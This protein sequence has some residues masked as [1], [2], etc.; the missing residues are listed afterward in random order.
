MVDV[1]LLEEYTLLTE[2]YS[3]RMFRLSCASPQLSRNMRGEY[4]SVSS[5]L[6]GDPVPHR[7]G[8]AAPNFSA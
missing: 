5:Q 2:L 3:P 7:K 4:S 6:D 1:L 8:T